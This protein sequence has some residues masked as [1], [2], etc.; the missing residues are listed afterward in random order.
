M[1]GGEERDGAEESSQTVV[2]PPACRVPG[3]CNI[4]ADVTYKSQ[5][6]E[7]EEEDYTRIKRGNG[8]ALLAVNARLY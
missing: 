1:H 4:S 2:S 6:E 3:S 8:G 7:E 5:L